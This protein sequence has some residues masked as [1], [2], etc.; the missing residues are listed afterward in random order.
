MVKTFLSRIILITMVSLLVACGSGKSKV[1]VDPESGLMWM[2]DDFSSF[3]GRFADSWD[4]AMAWP[5]KMNRI[6]Y[7][8]YDDWHVPSIREYRTMDRNSADRRRYRELFREAN[9]VHDWGKGAYA[10]WSRNEINRYVAS[11]ISFHDGFATS[12]D[13]RDQRNTLTG[14]PFGM[15]VRLVRRTG[16]QDASKRMRNDLR[17]L[18]V[19]TDN[20]TNLRPVVPRRIRGTGATSVYNSR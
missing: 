14:E 8:G 5:K 19:G 11:Y 15:S 3:E 4:E 20:S 6:R 2:K 17:T 9:V 7:G 13:K 18:S 10:F 16:G 12:G 1:V